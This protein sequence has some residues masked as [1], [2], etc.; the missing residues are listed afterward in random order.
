MLKK[1]A[2]HPGAYLLTEDVADLYGISLRKVREMTRLHQ[3]PHRVL[4][5]GR[6]C[7]FELQDLEAWANGAELESIQLSAGGRIVR[8]VAA[9]PP[10]THMQT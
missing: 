4:P 3:V 8:L 5:H 10:V 6:R 7:L 9:A 1:A 2:A